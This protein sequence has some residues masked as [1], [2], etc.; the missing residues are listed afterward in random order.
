MTDARDRAQW[1]LDEA[2]DKRGESEAAYY[3][4]HGWPEDYD[5]RS[6]KA[7]ADKSKLVLLGAGCL[8]ILVVLLVVLL[9]IS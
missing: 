4:E 6:S 9:Q 5:E 1:E 7:T 2:A 3:E 8:V